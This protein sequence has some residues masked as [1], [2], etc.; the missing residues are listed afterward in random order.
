MYESYSRQ[1]LPSKKYRELLGSA[2]CVF[3]S[4]NNFI[5]EN[6]L[7]LK[8]NTTWYELIDKE[9]GKL[10]N[11]IKNSISKVT[12]YDILNKFSDIIDKRNRIIHSFQITGDNG[13]QI[14]ATKERKTHT[15]YVITENF[16][17]D[18]IKLNDE[19]SDMLHDLRGY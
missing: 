19:L 18:F 9:S 4:N 12:G 3:V 6:I 1:A 13:E 11:D 7:N 17:L 14:L 2:I 5:I 16:L 15:Q 10:K 8:S